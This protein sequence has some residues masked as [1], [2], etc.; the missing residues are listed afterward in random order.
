[1]YE[2]INGLITNIYPAYLVIADRSGVGYKLFVANPYRFE[3]NVESHVYVE[4]IVRENEMTLY[5]FIDENEKY[6]FNKLLNVSGIG[7]KSALAILASDD[8]AGL[9]TAVAND[10]ASYLTQF[11]GVGKKTAQQIV[12]DLKGKL[13]DLALS[14]GMTVETVPTTDNQALADALAA[15]ESLGY[16]AKDVAK[17]QTALAN[18]KDTTDGY[19]RS[20]LKFLVK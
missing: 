1:M 12:L 9:V 8:A 3:Q 16:S 18:Q 7:P 11:P 4:Q 15:L 6:L 20:A 14:A 10:D 5:G 13:D 2:Y 17:L 19:I